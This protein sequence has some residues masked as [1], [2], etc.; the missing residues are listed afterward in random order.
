MKEET[1]RALSY[2]MYAIG[3]QGKERPSACIVNTVFQIV[4]SP[5]VIAVSMHHDNYSNQCIK[6]T[7]MFTVSVLSEDT[8]GTVIG[9]LGF[10]SGRDSDKL[11]NVRHKILQE[12]LPVLKE[13]ICCWFLCRVINSVETATHTVFLAEIVAG[14]DAVKGKPMT[15]S[16][17]HEVVKGTAPKNAPTYLANEPVADDEESYVCT[18]CGYV[19]NDPDEPF[20]DLPEDWVCPICGMPKSVFQRK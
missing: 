4:A 14:S 12:G 2:G 20:E 13:N 5:A 15:Y 3:V 11:R 6:D 16:Y 7:G 17:Y 8:S 9:A 19:Y 18:V 1:L 10:T